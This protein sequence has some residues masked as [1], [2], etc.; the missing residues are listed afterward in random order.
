MI[1]VLLAKTRSALALMATSVCKMILP[2][3]PASS[4]ISWLFFTGSAASCGCNS[5]ESI[6]NRGLVNPIVST[7]SK[8]AI[9]AT[10]LRGVFMT[11]ESQEGSCKADKDRD[12]CERVIGK[13]VR[14][15][16]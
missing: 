1:A 15:E 5:V 16:R 12:R 8:S 2:Q 14:D 10:F 9:P 13:H 4:E 6:V 7:T 11:G 3:C